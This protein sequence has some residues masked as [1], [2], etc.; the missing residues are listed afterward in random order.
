MPV[1][2][3]VASS[4]TLSG[5]SSPDASADS[6]IFLAIRSLSDPVGLSPSSFAHSRTDGFGDIRGMPTSR[7]LPI[8]SR[9][10]AD[11]MPAIIPGAASP[12]G[13]GVGAP[14]HDRGDLPGS[15]Q[16]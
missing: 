12:T 9:M 14:L 4:S 16:I 13:Q 11:R 15:R 3:L 2:P 7:V 5:V 8:A 1:F 10:S 6:I